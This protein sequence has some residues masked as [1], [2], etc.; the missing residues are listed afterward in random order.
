MQGSVKATAGL[1]GTDS[2]ALSFPEKDIG[3]YFLL[4]INFMIEAECL[5]FRVTL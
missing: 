1:R 2:N 4:V 5:L 3:S